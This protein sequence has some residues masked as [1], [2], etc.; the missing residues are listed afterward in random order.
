MTHNMGFI[1]S[2]IFSVIGLI[3]TG[4]AAP[5]GPNPAQSFEGHID[6]QANAETLIN[7]DQPVCD[8]GLGLG[9]S[10]YACQALTTSQFELQGIPEQ[11]PEFR[12]VYAD[13]SWAASEGTQNQ[14]DTDVTLT[15]PDGGMLAVT[16][17]ADIS[18]SFTDGMAMCQQLIPLICS[19]APV[20]LSCDLQFYAHHANLTEELSMY[21]AEGG[22]LNGSWSISDVTISGSSIADPQTAIAAVGSLTIGAWSLLLVYESP[23]LPSR[24]I[25]YYQGLE[26]NEGINRQLFPRGF[27]APPDPVVDL[28]LMVLEGDQQITGDQLLLNGRQITDQCNPAN[29]VFN[30]TVSMNNECRQNVTGVDLDRFVVNGAVLEGDTEAEL[31]LVI[32]TG[33]GFTTTGEQLFTHWLVL[34]FDHLLPTFDQ[35]KPEKYA[36]PPHEQPVAPGEV[37]SYE[38]RLQNIGE[39]PATNVI[40]RDLTPNGTSY[41]VGSAT[42]DM[43]PI[44]DGPQDSNPFAAGLNLNTLPQVGERIEINEGHAIRFQVQ[45]LQDPGEVIEVV[46]A[47][48]IS[49]DR[50]ESI[51]TNL[52]R[53]PI[54]RTINPPMGGE[55]VGGEMM[56]GD[57]AGDNDAGDVAGVGV[58]SGEMSSA[59]D[60][61]AGESMAGEEQLGGDVDGGDNTV[62]EPDNYCGEGTLF[63][64]ESQLCESICGPGLR[65]DSTCDPSRC[66]QESEPPCEGDGE[67]RGSSEGCQTQR[68]PLTS[69]LTITMWLM[70]ALISLR[71]R[72]RYRVDP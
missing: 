54:D 60:L 38:I 37:I 9:T 67:R 51:A 21:H 72:R 35:L 11:S 43:L 6:Y 33:N 42:V 18:E 12:L 61:P 1:L 46:N 4:D 63:N 71:Q 8:S 17:T 70:I 47:A 34:S 22:L 55:Q 36:N 62:M 50:I 20:N 16:A 32:P 52:V 30:S 24:K 69:P 39:A 40:L 28:T 64:E 10:S 45:V 7:C 53:H 58:N 2:I 49:A 15:T 68:S 48:E 56:A 31:E 26:L 29:N 27:T 25:Y 65:W 57:M 5:L 19:E 44:D 14:L 13:L 66:V 59:G 3:D 41:V 23:E